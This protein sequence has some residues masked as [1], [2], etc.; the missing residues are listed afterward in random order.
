MI[1]IILVNLFRSL[2]FC[3]TCFFFYN[4]NNLH[5][6]LE[7]PAGGLEGARSLHWKNCVAEKYN[8]QAGKKQRRGSGTIKSYLQKQYT[9]H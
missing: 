3:V 1:K 5:F 4:P 8:K 9:L 6:F 7:A 2:K